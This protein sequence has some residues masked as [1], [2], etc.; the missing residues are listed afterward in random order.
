MS[1]STLPPSRAHLALRH[2]PIPALRNL[3]LDE[4][5]EAVVIT[6][7]VASYYQKQLAQE[8]IMP[9]LGGRILYNRVAVVRQ[10]VENIVAGI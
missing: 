7:S 6:G 8:S 2:S 1:V 5:D 9:Y 4:S 10:T 3:S